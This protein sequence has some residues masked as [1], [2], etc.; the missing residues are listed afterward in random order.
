MTYDV[1]LESLSDNQPPAALNPWLTA[2]WWAR[3]GDWD[4][5]HRMVQEMPDRK[6]ARI[7]AYLH[8]VEGDDWNSRYW[9][10]RAG[11]R[12]PA[13]MSHE[14]EWEMLVRQLLDE[15]VDS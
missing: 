4:R 15:A 13:E 3:K 10:Q 9:H 8:R 7:H 6:A 11:T 14:E 1:F 5:A 12:F 2:L